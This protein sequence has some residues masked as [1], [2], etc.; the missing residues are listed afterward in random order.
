MREL[1]FNRS[2]TMVSRNRIVALL[3]NLALSMVLV[4]LQVN[5][6]GEEVMKKSSL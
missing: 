5:A 3:L 6:T 1:L 4:I 2:F